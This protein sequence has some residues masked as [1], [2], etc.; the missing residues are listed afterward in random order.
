MIFIPINCL[1]W[2]RIG[3]YG[4]KSNITPNIDKRC[5]NAIIF[6]N[7]IANGP[8]TPTSFYSIFTSNIPCL[9][10]FYTPLP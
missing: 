5:K 9:D 3:I 6:K 2:D 10:E 4:N 7:A 1:R 8:N